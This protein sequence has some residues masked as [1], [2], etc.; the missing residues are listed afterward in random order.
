MEFIYWDCVIRDEL[1]LPRRFS[2]VFAG[3]GVTVG[4]E[5]VVRDV[6]SSERVNLGKII[7]IFEYHKNCYLRVDTTKG[8]I[9]MTIAPLVY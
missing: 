9:E 8:K 7:R 3:R 2:C 1:K 5:L 6:N 4:T